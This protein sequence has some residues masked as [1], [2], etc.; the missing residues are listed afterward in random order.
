MSVQVYCSNPDCG[1][2]LNLSGGSLERKRRCQKCGH[3]I[4]FDLPEAEHAPGGFS[5]G[6]FTRPGRVVAAGAAAI[7]ILGIIIYAFVDQGRKEA[8]GEDPEVA[9][10]A[11]DAGRPAGARDP[12]VAEIG[13][14]KGGNQRSGLDLG[15]FYVESGEWRIVDEELQQLSGEPGWSTLL[16]GDPAWTDYDF[17][18]DLERIA[19][20]NGTSLEVRRQDDN[21][22]V[23]LNFCFATRPPNGLFSKTQ[24]TIRQLQSDDGFA[25]VDHHWYRAIVSVRG[26]QAIG[27]ILDGDAEVL[28]LSA[29]IEDHPQGYVGLASWGAIYHYKN[30]KVTAPD[31][32][33]LWEGLPAIGSEIATR[34]AGGDLHAKSAAR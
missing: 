12:S 23:S 3:V 9:G 25:L 26:G 11:D 2:V 16:F 30:I 32:A 13:Q 21:N 33:V 14:A 5:R 31:G 10:K 15:A 17:S 27:S 29:T 4:T 24:G 28:R 18:V 20:E 7:L 1:A 19:G 6:L 22:I 34:G 8:E